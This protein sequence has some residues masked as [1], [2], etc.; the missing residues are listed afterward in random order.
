M[1]RTTIPVL[2]FRHFLTYDELTDYVKALAAARPGLAGLGSLGTSREGREIWRLTIT[3]Y[4]TGAPEDKPAYLIHGNIHAPELSGAHAA[5][6]TAQRLLS[7]YP[8]RTKLLE[9]V[10]FHIVPRLNPDGAEAVVTTSANVRSRMDCANLPP[11]TLVGK[12]MDGN[13]LVVSM[14]QERPDGDMARD[15]KDPRLLVR[16]QADSEGPFYKVYAEG[17]ILNWDGSDSIRSEGR[18]IDW[19]RQWG[20]DWKPEPE[21]GGAGDFPYSEPEMRAIAEFITGSSN[22]FGILGYHTGPAAFLRP[23]SA[24]GDD[25]LD[26]GDVRRMEE[27]GAVATEHTGL[28]VTPVYRYCSTRSRG[29]KLHGHFPSTGYQHFGLFVFEFE[30]GTIMDSAGMGF[31]EVMSWQTEE[32]RLEGPRRLMRWWDR[33]GRKPV[34]FLPWKKFR[35]PQLGPVEIGGRVLR[36]WAG[37]TLPDLKK[38]CEGTYKYTLHHAGQHPDVRLEQARAEAVGEGLWRVRARVANRGVFPTHVSARGAKL[39]RPPTV[40]VEFHPPRGAELLSQHGHQEIGHLAGATGS[41]AL[42]WFVRAPA[43]S[44]C[45]IAV[46]GGAGGNDSAVVKLKRP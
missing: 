30:L 16:R 33:N 15:P 29:L 10:A 40:R 7:D 37:M 41:R 8:S 12:D 9:R 19:N 44:A 6:Y 43:G 11:N 36:D 34:I 45:R 23:P 13:G 20:F 28:P 27:L 4:A 32:Q 22:L 18:H 5:L 46:F 1:P 42:E 31:K 26:E 17:E 25:A 14:R 35:H 38:R 39:K 24:P 21:Q 2:P 3:D